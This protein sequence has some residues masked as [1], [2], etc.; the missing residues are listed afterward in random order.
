[1]WI[2][3]ATGASSCLEFYV[4][5]ICIFEVKETKHGT[6]SS[7]FLLLTTFGSAVYKSVKFWIISVELWKERYKWIHIPSTY[8]PLSRCISPSSPLFPSTSC[9][10][11]PCS[12]QSLSISH[13]NTDNIHH[14]QG[15]DAFPVS[16]N[17]IYG[18]F[19]I[20]VHFHLVHFPKCS[21]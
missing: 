9:L 17:C 15:P 3:L 6:V 2:T 8:R 4:R 14:I 10:T 11:S 1:M 16:V 21:K 7:I 20:S 12:S 18:S 13:F 5:Q 19:L